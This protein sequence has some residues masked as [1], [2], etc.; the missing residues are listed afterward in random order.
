MIKIKR[1]T[2]FTINDPE[3]PIPIKDAKG[4]CG[5]FCVGADLN[6]DEA[7]T[8]IDSFDFKEPIERK[9]RKEYV[10]PGK[11]KV[12]LFWICGIESSLKETTEEQKM[13]EE[14]RPTT[15][16][17][18]IEQDPFWAGVCNINAVFAIALSGFCVAFFNRYES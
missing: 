13:E 2:Y 16:D 18:S 15:V 7:E 8:R 5:N 14:E 11:F 9:P 3:E 17:T 1:L 4:I 12:A 6:E 10:K